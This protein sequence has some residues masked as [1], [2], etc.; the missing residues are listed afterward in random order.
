MST[1]FTVGSSHTYP[2]V[3]L[4]LAAAPSTPTGGYFLDMYPDSEFSTSTDTPLAGFTTSAANFI[5]VRAATGQ[6]YS[7]A[8]S[9]VGRYDSSKGVAWKTT[10]TYGNGVCL[11][12]NNDY[13]NVSGIQFKATS[14]KARAIFNIKGGG[15]GAHC[16]VDRIIVETPGPQDGGGACAISNC[17]DATNILVVVRSTSTSGPGINGQSDSFGGKIINCTVVRPTDFTAGGNGISTNYNNQTIKNNAIF[18]FTTP[19]SG[20]ATGSCTFN[21]TDQASCAGSSNV[22]SVAFTTATFDTVVDTNYN[23][24]LVTGSALLNVGTN[25]GAPAADG[26]GTSRPQ[27]T[28]VD[29]GWHEFVAGGGGTVLSRYYY[30]QHIA[31]AA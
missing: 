28:T 13:V 5:T 17:N 21:A 31:R 22:T 29:M 30:N 15:S 8:A 9:P 3:A 19:I 1:T 11:S 20:S 25:T 14:N 12:V 23:Y 10:G 2:S 4:A 24:R 7:D 26:F 18:G 16:T 27:N 6:A